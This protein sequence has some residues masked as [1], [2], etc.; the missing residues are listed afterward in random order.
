MIY[1][2]QTKN[3]NLISQLA[4][5]GTTRI[6][7]KQVGIWLISA[8]TMISGLTCWISFRRFQ[9][10]HCIY[11]FHTKLTLLMKESLRQ[12]KI[13]IIM[14]RPCV[15][16]TLQVKSLTNN[17]HYCWAT[18]TDVQMRF[19]LFFKHREQKKKF[20]ISK[21]QNQGIQTG[22]SGKELILGGF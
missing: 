18:W 8:K 7:C 17:N 20:Q 13:I 3:K 11:I 19:N 15:R 21:E 6:I 1:Q 22:N 9:V 5:W 4:V 2:T 14:L 10:R 12:K 16:A